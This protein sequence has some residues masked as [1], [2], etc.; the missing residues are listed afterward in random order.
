MKEARKSKG[1]V[2]WG[3]YGRFQFLRKTK[4]KLLMKMTNRR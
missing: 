4:K 3:N 2:F 1:P